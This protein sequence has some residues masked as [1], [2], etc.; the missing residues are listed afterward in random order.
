MK[1]TSLGILGNPIGDTGVG[2]G[3]SISKSGSVEYEFSEY[4][5]EGEGEYGGVNGE[6]YFEV[7]GDPSSNPRTCFH[8]EFEPRRNILEVQL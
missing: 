7:V 8:F 4:S 1:V 5:G 2:R 6:L 3:D